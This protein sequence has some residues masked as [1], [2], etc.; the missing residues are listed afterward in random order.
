MSSRQKLSGRAADDDAWLLEKMAKLSNGSSNAPP[1]SSTVSSSTTLPTSTLS[2]SSNLAPSASP[3]KLPQPAAASQIAHPKHAMDAP[4]PTQQPNTSTHNDNGSSQSRR[5]QPRHGERQSD[6]AARS[7]RTPSEAR[8]RS[9]DN[10][11]Y[12]TS[13]FN[14]GKSD[15]RN[16]PASAAEDDYYDDADA[17]EEYS[18]DG[19]ES[20]TPSVAAASR[21]ATATLGQ[22][23]RAARDHHNPHSPDMYARKG[24]EEEEEKEDERRRRQRFRSKSGGSSHSSGGRGNSRSGSSGAGS[25]TD[26]VG[27]GSDDEGKR[28]GRRSARDRSAKSRMNELQARAVMQKM[29]K[30]A[31]DLQ[32]LIQLDPSPHSLIFDLAPLSSYE[33]YIRTYGSSTSTQSFTQSPDPSSFTTTDAGQTEDWRVE[34]RW[35]QAPPEGWVEC[36]NVAPEHLAGIVDVAGAAEGKGPRKKGRETGVRDALSSKIILAAGMEVEGWRRLMGFL[37]RAGQV[38]EALL[39][40][41]L[42]PRQTEWRRSSDSVRGASA[43][44]HSVAA[45]ER[46]PF[47][48]GRIPLFSVFSPVSHKTVLVAWSVPPDPEL[49]DRLAT[50][51]IISIHRSAEWNAPFRVLLCNGNPTHI[52]IHPSAPQIVLVGTADG[53]LSA[54]DIQQ[55]QAP[56]RTARDGTEGIFSPAKDFMPE[57]GILRQPSYSVDGVGTVEELHRGAILAIVPVAQGEDGQDDEVVGNDGDEDEEGAKS[58][59]VISVDE[60]GLLHVWALMVLNDSNVDIIGLSETDYGMGPG[61][62]VKLI[63]SATLSLNPRRR[64]A[65]VAGDPVLTVCTP[66][67]NNTDSFL[68]GTES[69]GV[70]YNRSRFTRACVPSRFHLSTATSLAKATSAAPAETEAPEE[71]ASDPAARDQ[72]IDAVTAIDFNPFTPHLFVASTHSSSQ[73]LLFHATSS[74]EPVASWVL[75]AGGGGV[76]KVVWS[77]HRPAVFYALTSAAQ[78]LVWDLLEHDGGPS[79]CV[80]FAPPPRLDAASTAAAASH[81]LGPVTDICLSPTALA[82][83]AGWQKKPLLGGGMAGATSRTATLVVCFTDG[84]V[85]RHALVEELGEPSVDELEALEAWIAKRL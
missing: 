28:G 85:E 69:G 24:E 29:V 31:R 14:R 55:A 77:S 56:I 20:L 33:L 60:T 61:S 66:N 70:I 51:G 75:P 36:A 30:R 73:V 47:L 63:R 12:A 82:T 84:R 44:S 46:T 35:T 72:I 7:S 8:D 21:P 74:D 40:E 42:D 25:A 41:N 53:G 71:P 80:D 4:P 11:Q 83:A 81:L 23:R 5:D 49:G 26:D 52:S 27:S 79:H 39:D 15:T 18:D 6:R 59:Q 3:P 1:A 68:C 65:A 37:R 16:A 2:S 43:I 32:A 22:H 54:Y 67:P 10:E 38:I 45:F 57:D 17:F 13:G 48:A 9:L 34:D 19:F 64:H 58:F 78:V 62:R 50:K 76:K